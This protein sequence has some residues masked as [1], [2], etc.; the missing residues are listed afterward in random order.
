MFDQDF[1]Q[2]LKF[3]YESTGCA[4]IPCLMCAS[5]RV[6][7]GSIDEFRTELVGQVNFLDK[8]AT[9]FSKCFQLRETFGLGLNFW[10]TRFLPILRNASSPF[11][12]I[13]K[14]VLCR[15]IALFN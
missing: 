13:F 15:L 5:P 4:I 3:L 11:I 7:L 6:L 2:N 1:S 12:Q 14:A 10:V 8:I 9:S